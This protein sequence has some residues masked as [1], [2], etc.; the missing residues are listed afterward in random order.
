MALSAS[1][2]Q[3]ALVLAVALLL[4]ACASGPSGSSKSPR[5]RDG[6]PP[7]AVDLSKIAE[8]VPKAEPRARYGNHSP[9]TV[10]GKT[11]RVLP[12]RAGYVAEGTASWYGTLFHGRLTS[13]REPYDMYAFTAAHKELPLPSYARVT[14]LENSRSIVVRINDRGPFVGDRIIDLSYVAAL[15][16]DMHMRGTAR[17]RVETITP[18]E[19]PALAAL[20]NPAP[21]PVA[22]PTAQAALERGVWLQCGAFA[23]ANSARGLMLALQDAGFADAQVRVGVDGLHRVMLGPLLNQDAAHE[24]TLQLLARGFAAPKIVR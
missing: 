21:T 13:T 12:E 3:R 16:L 19:T 14:N 11:Y 18:G 17:V 22:T 7:K 8:P 24:L 10:L 23:A 1:W 2:L 9:Y 4:G 5:Y 6:A 15:K 20:P